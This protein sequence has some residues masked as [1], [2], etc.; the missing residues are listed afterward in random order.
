MMFTL[1]FS[2]SYEE[3]TEEVKNAIGKHDFYEVKNLLFFKKEL[4]KSV[5]KK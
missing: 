1:D 3:Q 4:K 2:K 5:D